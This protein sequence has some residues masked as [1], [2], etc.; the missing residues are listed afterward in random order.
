M[1][2]GLRKIVYRNGDVN[3]SMVKALAFIP[4]NDRV[5]I[6]R[7]DPSWVNDELCW[8]ACP[9]APNSKGRDSHVLAAFIASG[10]SEWDV[11]EAT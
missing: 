11:R 2:H 7:S 9:I 5:H 8:V 1:V 4:P 3:Q 10:D 6:A